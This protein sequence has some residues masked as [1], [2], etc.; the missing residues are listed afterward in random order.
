MASV[1]QFRLLAPG[2]SARARENCPDDGAAWAADNDLLDRLKGDAA[3]AGVDFAWVETEGYSYGRAPE[4][5]GE[6]LAQEVA[7]IRERYRHPL[8]QSAEPAV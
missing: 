7:P 5:V 4:Q 3:F 6:F 2:V 8:G 1:P